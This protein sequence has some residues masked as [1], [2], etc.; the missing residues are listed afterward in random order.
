MSEHEIVEAVRAACAS[1]L[2]EPDR[3]NGYW[4]VHWAA[5]ADGP[6][7][8][9]DPVEATD[10]ERIIIGALPTDTVAGRISEVVSAL[11]GRPLYDGREAW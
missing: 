8:A 1:T 3:L 10:P 6:M 5:T 2:Q 7:I 4:C 9:V 11:T